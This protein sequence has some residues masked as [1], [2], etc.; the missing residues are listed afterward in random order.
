MNIESLYIVYTKEE[1]PKVDSRT[2]SDTANRIVGHEIVVSKVNPIAELGVASRPASGI[3]ESAYLSNK[4][5]GSSVQ[6]S[7]YSMSVS[8]QWSSQGHLL[9]VSLAVP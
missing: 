9:S 5:R 6:V 4:W 3:G 2:G 8:V 7:Y 1:T